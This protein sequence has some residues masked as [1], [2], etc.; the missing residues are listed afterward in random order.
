MLLGM[1]DH[2]GG[3]ECSPERRKKRNGP[4][5][6]NI[7]QADNRQVMKNIDLLVDMYHRFVPFP[8]YTE[9]TNTGCPPRDYTTLHTLKKPRTLRYSTKTV[10]GRAYPQKPPPLLTYVHTIPRCLK[11]LRHL[12]LPSPSSKHRI[13]LRHHI[14]AAV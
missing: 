5:T 6:D 10:Y 13:V 14:H 1:H 4:P 11:L 8:L 9:A 3:N 12:A 7:R 2:V